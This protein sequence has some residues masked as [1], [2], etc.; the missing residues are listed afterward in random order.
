MKKVFA[1]VLAAVLALGSSTM[2]FASTHVK[3]ITIG[4]DNGSIY[5]L[6]DDDHMVKADVSN[7]K[8]NND[9]TTVSASGDFNANETYYIPVYAG[10]NTPITKLSDLD[11]YK[12]RTSVSDGSNYISS[13]PQFVIKSVKNGGDITGKN[14]FIQVTTADKFQ[15][16]AVDFDLTTTV[17]PKEGSKVNMGSLVTNLAEGDEAEMNISG[18]IGYETTDAKSYTVMEG[19]VTNFDDVDDDDT[20]E[21]DFG[22]D[23]L[24]EVNAKGQKDLFLRLDTSDSALEDKYPE[25]SL[26]VRYFAGNN[27]TFRKTGT[28][29]FEDID[30][31]EN[32]N[33]KLVAPYIY[34]VVNGKLVVFNDAK[35]DMDESKFTIKTNKLGN[36]VISDRELDASE[37]IDGEGEN[38]GGSSNGGSNSEKNPDTGANDFVGLAVALAVVS[39]AGIAVAKR[40]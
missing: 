20:I 34:E 10:T 23:A 39:I 36:Y 1:Y 8:W 25:A 29:T 13:K 21:L 6:N 12:I 2:A 19:P 3:E 32:E 30:P 11:N 7:I 38:E 22:G 18:T 14:A 27:K 31:I 5:V 9:S 28:L 4:D 26:E 17:F 40:K 24:F 33:G 16:E 37:A 35:Y 15:M